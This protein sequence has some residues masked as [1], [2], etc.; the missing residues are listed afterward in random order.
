[1]MDGSKTKAMESA[2]S[3]SGSTN[4]GGTF[5][6][7]ITLACCCSNRPCVLLHYEEEASGLL[8][9]K[10]NCSGTHPHLCR[11]VWR[12]HGF[13]G[14]HSAQRTRRQELWLSLGGG[15]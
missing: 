15:Q 1:M 7:V 11:Q 13:H 9:I 6:Y 2:A 3:Y 5:K 10:K 4:P 14:L 8:W 12:Q